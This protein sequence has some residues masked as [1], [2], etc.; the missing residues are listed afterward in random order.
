MSTPAT[1]A[2]LARTI[3]LRSVHAYLGANG[4]NREESLGGDTADIYVLAEDEREAAIVPAS[5][6]YGDY[7]TRIYQIAE[8]VGRVEGRQMLAVLMDLALAESDLVRVRLP[9]ADDDNAVSLADGAAA[10]D[11]AKGL[12]LAAACSADRP[13]RMYRAGRNRRAVDY[14]RKVRLGQTEP[15]SFVINILSPVPPSLQNTLFSEEPFERRVARK[16]VSGLQAS[17]RATDRVN[18]GAAG[19]GDF[20]ERV[21]DGVSANLCRSVAR[22]TEVGG[23]L[24]VAVSWAMTRPDASEAPERVAVRFRPPDAPVLDEAA[25]VLAHRQERTDEEIQG[26]VSRLARDQTD[27]QGTATIKAFVDGRLTSVKAVFDPTDYSEIT[28]AHDDRLSVSLEGDLRREGQRWRLR[29]PRQVTILR[30]EE[31]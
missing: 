24:E 6:H 5:E 30:E 9:N 27:P 28:R 26:Y 12:L 29:N 17:R 21:D 11:E 2:A 3:G 25:R 1:E 10:L 20:E 16:L 18:R 13:Q 4:W 8:Q 14:L 23:G 15:G 19:I 22:L 7:G 31:G